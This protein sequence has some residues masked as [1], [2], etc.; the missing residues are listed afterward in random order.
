MEL[1]ETGNPTES[2]RH[3]HLFKPCQLFS[4]G[5]CISAGAP[6]PH[7]WVCSHFGSRLGLSGAGPPLVTGVHRQPAA[8]MQFTPPD[9][10]VQPPP[11]PTPANLAPQF[12][13]AMPS[14]PELPTA[15]P[16]STTLTAA[17][18]WHA[19]CPAEEQWFLASGVDPAVLEELATLS[20]KDRRQIM[21]GTMKKNPQYVDSWVRK[22]VATAKEQS[23][24][25]R[26]EPYQVYRPPP[27][28]TVLPTPMLLHS[29]PPPPTPAM[30][31]SPGGSSSTMG[32]PAQGISPVRTEPALW[33]GSGGAVGQPP[34]W[35]TQAYQNKDEPSQML[36]LVMNQLDG[37]TTMALSF[38]PVKLQLHVGMATII[39]PT[40]WNNPTQ[41]V[42][43]CLKV[44]NMLTPPAV[45]ASPAPTTEPP[46][47]STLK[48]VV[49]HCCVGIGTSHLVLNAAVA[50]LRRSRPLVRIEIP[51]VYSFETDEQAKLMES[52][53]AASLRMTYTPCGD[54]LNLPE[55]VRQKKGGWKAQGLRVL[56]MNSW[57]C[58]N[59][60]KA[61]RPRERPPGS[62]LHMEHSRAMWPIVEAMSNLRPEFSEREL[63]HFT[64]YPECGN[65]GEEQTINE[66][67]GEPLKHD[68]GYYKVSRSRNVRSNPGPLAPVHNHAPHD[69]AMKEDEWSWKGN[70]DGNAM[71]ESSDYPTVVLRSFLPKLMT[72][73]VFEGLSGLQHGE[74]ASLY[75]MKMVHGPT[76]EERYIGRAFW[77]R[78]LGHSA[79]P[80]VAA[81]NQH[82]PC[83][84]WIISST[85]GPCPQ[86]VDG[87]ESCG[88]QRYCSNCE[89]LTRLLGQSWHF[90]SM[91][92]GTTSL[93][94]AI[95]DNTGATAAP[96]GRWVWPSGPTHKCGPSCP[97]NP[98][99]GR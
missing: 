90:P 4:Q 67:F 18:G 52:S 60:S 21:I 75:S 28:P 80:I 97:E 45:P 40:A 77:F 74:R 46:T 94:E 86:G 71:R 88:K 23:P 41:H 17:V 56:F 72:M 58:K 66:F 20:M 9:Q 19:N 78:W 82:Y 29:L 73:A 98:H 51:E 59:T 26:P 38:L 8:A 7:P 89:T 15:T 81:A 63:Y 25:G 44:I 13:A 50:L 55:V 42:Q 36:K 91:V 35:A 57:P 1:P 16:L 39:A 2:Q 11:R 14:P 5:C 61:A 12:A 95:I 37:P 48:L 96:G 64:E 54:V 47:G 70:H 32:S 69:P 53:V 99:K 33:A 49:L 65:M 10:L 85:G 30:V 83:L 93:L 92:D 6:N 87:G 27:P 84:Q 62:G 24:Y 3:L 79:T 68:T 22:C 34:V 43:Q 31:H 76:G